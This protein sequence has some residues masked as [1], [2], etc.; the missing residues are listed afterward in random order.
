MCSEWGLRQEC[1][2]SLDGLSL[3]ALTCSVGCRQHRKRR[4]AKAKVDPVALEAT[5][6]VR[7]LV[8]AGG[9]DAVQQVLKQELTPIVR[10]AIDAS[11]LE[12]IDKMV[13][14]TPQAV[15]V[16]AKDMEGEDAV[17]RQRAAALVVK[18]TVGHPA[19]VR[20]ADEQ[21]PEKLEIHFNLP[22]PDGEP[23]VE[24]PLVD[25][26]G[27]ALEESRVCD[28]CGIEKP[29]TEFVAGS[30]RCEQCFRET[31]DAILRRFQ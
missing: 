30:D 20:P 14:L 10:E 11:V 19:L 31:R 13:K 28:M 18:Y 4:L 23:A 27:E 7:E 25:E 2:G 16:L 26:E 15:E 5:A 3:Q 9:Q 21:P 8:R 12:A 29:H 1:K 6:G 17:L 22:R 24:V